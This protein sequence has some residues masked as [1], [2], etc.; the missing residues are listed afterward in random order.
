[1]HIYFLLKR[2]FYFQTALSSFGVQGRDSSS[3]LGT[4]TTTLTTAL[5]TLAKVV[6]SLKTNVTNIE[7]D[8]AVSTK[9]PA[10]SY[11]YVKS[12]IILSNIELTLSVKIS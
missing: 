1:M 2:F 3:A 8:I 5:S 12:N 9:K 10:N 11:F 7:T 4:L 6:L